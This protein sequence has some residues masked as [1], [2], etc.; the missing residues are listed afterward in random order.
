[1]KFTVVM[2]SRLANYPNAARNREAKLLR[3]IA[4]VIDQTFTDWELNIIA[5][6]C[7]R[8]VDIVK[9][10]I[11]DERVNLFLIQHHKLWSGNPRNT[12]IMQGKGEWIIYLDIDDL[13]G[14][15]HLQL[16]S[17]GVAAYD[18]VWFN[19]IRYRERL[20]YW[21]ENPCDIHIIGKHGTSNIAHRREL[22][23]FW[24]EDGKYAHDHHFIQQLLTNNNFAKIPAPEYFV[25][26][27]PGTGFS[28]GYDV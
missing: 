16:V 1:M 13:Y 11:T 2:A 6:G 9:E 15:N 27:V 19:D 28:G 26:H 8:T 22:N 17:D 25:C 23:M 14:E 21:Y 7:Q 3:A 10:K 4:S 20:G 12:G 18:W 5:D 24:P